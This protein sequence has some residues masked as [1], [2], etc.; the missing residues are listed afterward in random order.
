[1]IDLARS[2]IGT[3]YVY[4]AMSPT[5]GFDCSGFTSYI[6][7]TLFAIKLPHSSRDQSRLGVQVSSSEIEVGDILCF[8]WSGS[9][10]ICDH[11]GLYIGNGQYVHASSSDRTYFTDSGAVKEATVNFSRNPIISIRR[12][13]Y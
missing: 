4:A 12:I 1:M 9:D 13:I 2:L 11:V 8:D 10:G 6:Y 5:A 7:K 3:R